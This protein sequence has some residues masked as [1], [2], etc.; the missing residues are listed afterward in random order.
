MPITCVSVHDL[1]PGVSA[2]GHANFLI[3]TVWRKTASIWHGGKGIN[4]APHT[5][6]HKLGLVKNKVFL[7][8]TLSKL[9]DSSFKPSRN[10]RDN[11]DYSSIPVNANHHGHIYCIMKYHQW[12]AFKTITYMIA[13]NLVVEWFSIRYQAAEKFSLVKSALIPGKSDSK[14]FWGNLPLKNEYSFLQ[15]NKQFAIKRVTKNPK[16]TTNPK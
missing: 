6:H 10:T 11:R 9:A 7:R 4:N 8:N 5:P 15:W 3:P 2:Q 14:S 1:T 16:L 12:P 13:T